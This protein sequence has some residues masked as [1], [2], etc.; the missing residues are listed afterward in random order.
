MT[1][2]YDNYHAIQFH[3]ENEQ[4]LNQLEQLKSQVRKREIMLGRML[5][6]F[7]VET[8]YT[9]LTSQNQL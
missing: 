6:P 5:M 4:Q 9:A 3:S 2:E 7:E 8:L 1:K